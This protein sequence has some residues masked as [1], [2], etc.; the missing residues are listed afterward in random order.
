[1]IGIFSVLPVDSF[2]RGRDNQLAAGDQNAN[3][4][5]KEP[6]WIRYMLDG[7]EG[8]YHIDGTIRERN[9][10]SGAR[11]GVQPILASG[12]KADRF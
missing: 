4:L 12:M 8:N 9:L 10:F 5:A 2:I 7:F 6:M 11:P 1:M 3:T